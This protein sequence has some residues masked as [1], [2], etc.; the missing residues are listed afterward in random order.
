MRLPGVEDT[1]PEGGMRP[2]LQA[3]ARSA[4]E[5][6]PV[7]GRK[8]AADTCAAPGIKK[9]GAPSGSAPEAAWE[10]GLVRRPQ[11]LSGMAPAPLL[12]FPS[13]PLPQQASY[14]LVPLSPLPLY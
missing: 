3:G 13:Q 8:G 12:H 11:L 14:S 1:P 10:G 9:E 2:V 7:V 6:S 4:E 5:A